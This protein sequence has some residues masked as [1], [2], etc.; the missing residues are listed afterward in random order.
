MRNWIVNNNYFR[1]CLKFYF[2]VSIP[3]LKDEASELIDGITTHFTFLRLT[4]SVIEKVK[5]KDN[6][7][8]MRMRVKLILTKMYFQFFELCF[9]FWDKNVRQKD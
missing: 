2:S 4:T 3:D 7:Q 6:F 8:L 9:E 5:R 1:N